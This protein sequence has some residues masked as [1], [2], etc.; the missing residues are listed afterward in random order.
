[1]INAFGAAAFLYSLIDSYL[2]LAPS[3]FVSSSAVMDSCGRLVFCSLSNADIALLIMSL[4]VFSL[5]NHHYHLPHICHIYICLSI[6]GKSL[7]I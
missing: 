2:L 5:H 1:M 3:A 7:L 6:D 4:M